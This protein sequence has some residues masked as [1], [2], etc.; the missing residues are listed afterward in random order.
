MLTCRV[1]A[2]VGGNK[3][4]PDRIDRPEKYEYEI[5][6]D[7]TKR[8]T[9]IDADRSSSLIL[10][11]SITS[12]EAALAW[13]ALFPHIVKCVATV[14]GFAPICKRVAVQ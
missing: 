9:R 14:V 1:S 6:Y 11:R 12:K 4:G 10:G 3:A 2:A 8:R 5:Q 7:M 13:K